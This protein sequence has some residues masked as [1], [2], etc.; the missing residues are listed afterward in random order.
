[1]IPNSP[2]NRAKRAYKALS[3]NRNTLYNRMVDFILENRSRLRD[4]TG[5]TE[6]S[7]FTLLQM[8]EQFLQKMQVLD[9]C[10][11]ELARPEPKEGHTTTTTY[12]TVE[13]NAKREELPQKIADALAERGESELLDLCVLRAD[14]TGA[15]VLLVL[16]REDYDVPV[17]PAKPAEKQEQQQEG[18]SGQSGASELSGQTEF[19][20][21]IPNGL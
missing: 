3:S 19:G 15:E 7:G 4:E 10:M 12:E 18:Q 13:V 5:G 14:D 21:D 16:A 11:C 2:E 20:D 17:K 9:R 8:D 1:M 6:L